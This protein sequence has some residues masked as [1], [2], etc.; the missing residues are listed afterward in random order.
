MEMSIVKNHQIIWD[1]G[2]GDFSLSVRTH[3]DNPDYVLL[4]LRNEYNQLVGD[5]M[6]LPLQ[7]AK[8]FHMVLRD[9]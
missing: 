2:H 4:S 1:D 8:S 3:P 5:E 6:H 7:V 9:F